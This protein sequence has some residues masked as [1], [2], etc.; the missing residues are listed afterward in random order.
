MD[1]T[2]LCLRNG[3]LHLISF[4]CLN[5]VKEQER[6]RKSA[7]LSVTVF[8]IRQCPET[9]TLTAILNQNAKSIRGFEPGLFG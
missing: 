9:L 8:R 4:Q 2:S 3:T 6:R 1:F 7:T 5:D